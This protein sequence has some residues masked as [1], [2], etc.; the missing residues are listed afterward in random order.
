[1]HVSTSLQ[2][3]H[4]LSLKFYVHA[5]LHFLEESNAKILVSTNY[6]GFNQIVERLFGN[7]N[8]KYFLNLLLI[9]LLGELQRNQG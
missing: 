9:F 3:G 1:M 6:I 4:L 8:G 2:L 7:F 5:N